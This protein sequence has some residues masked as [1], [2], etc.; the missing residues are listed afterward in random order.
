MSNVTG[1]STGA[2]V[3][4]GAA[5]V[6]EAQAPLKDLLETLPDVGTVVATGDPPLPFDYH[7]ALLSAPRAFATFVSHAEMAERLGLGALVRTLH[8][9]NS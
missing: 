2:A 5:V 9:R 3:L 4:C 1:T 8:F 6:M 7:C